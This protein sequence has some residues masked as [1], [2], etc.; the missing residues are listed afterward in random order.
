MRGMNDVLARVELSG[1]VEHRRGQQ[2]VEGTG[3][4]GDGYARVHRIEPHGFASH[5]VKGGIALAVSRGRRDTTYALGGEN[6]VL[7]PDLPQGAVALYDA[8]GNIIKLIGSG[9]VF[10][11]GSRTATLTAGDWTIN[12]TVTINGDVIVNGNLTASG[13]VTDGDGDGGA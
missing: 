8:G 10:D 2:F 4:A 3:F 9:A 11:F 5:P 7:R 13:S 6:P 12:G 1:K